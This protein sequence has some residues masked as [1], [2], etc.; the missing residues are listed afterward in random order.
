MYVNISGRRSRM[1]EIMW[2]SRPLHVAYKDPY[3][4]CF[5][6]RG[7]DIFNVAKGEWIQ[8]LQFAKVILKKKIK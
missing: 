1:E 8:I 3:L 2:P 6:E 7:I 4:M 5:C